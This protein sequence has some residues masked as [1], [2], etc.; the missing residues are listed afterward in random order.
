MS[1]HKAISSASVKNN[2]G[3]GFGLR[4]SSP[5]LNSVDLG[6]EATRTGSIVVDGTDTDPATAGVFAYNDQ[7]PIA[8]RLTTSLAGL[9]NDFLLSGAGEP[10]LIVS[11]H[12]IESITTRRT[13]TAIRA[14]YFNFY[15]GKFTT[16]PTNVVDSFTGSDSTSNDY[17]ARVSRK[18]P[19]RLTYKLGNPAAVTVGYKPKTN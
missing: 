7:L 19:G 4:H 16:S 13:A 8:K 1:T 15:T 12:K 11:V 2:H 18:L 9:S 17:A 6:L 3:V 5:I 10:N 14:G